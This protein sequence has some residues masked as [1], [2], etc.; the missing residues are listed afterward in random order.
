MARTLG[1]ILTERISAA[2][3]EGNRVAGE[4]RSY[5]DEE[6]DELQ[7]MHAEALAA[8][9]AVQI[10]GVLAG[11]EVAAI[12]LGVPGVIRSGIVEESPNLQ[13]LKGFNI[14]QSV[15]ASLRQK[16]V[17]TP[18]QIC[19]D[20]D[21][22]AAGIAAVR[23]QLDRLIRVWT[24]GNGIG[25]GLYPS[26][27]GVWEG[28]HSV[29][30]LDPKE[31]YCGCGGVGHLEGIMGHRAMRL[32][33]LD[34]EPEEVFEAAKRGDAR[35]TDFVKLWHRALA[36]GTAN[37]IHLDGPGRFYIAGPNADFLDV[38]LLGGYLQD[39]VKMSPLQGSYFQIVPTSHDMAL[40][41]A[42]VASRA[43]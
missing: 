7:G 28:G 11:Q 16:G 32:R 31:A 22:M 4:I 40:I 9:L 24:L 27:E 18:V 2:L 13:Q 8:E 19:N 17:G 6:G 1:V 36:A 15:E 3:V 42:A 39:M 10:A 41:G 23:G 12:G 43:R 37:S 34:M 30:T 38:R 20:A 14:K 25:F 26:A 5:P 29:V 35:C 33:F 21:V